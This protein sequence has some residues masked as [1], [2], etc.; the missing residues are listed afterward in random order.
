MLLPFFSFHVTVGADEFAGPE[1]VPELIGWWP[2]PLREVRSVKSCAA[3][4][5]LLLVGRVGVVKVQGA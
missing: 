3:L 4:V 2:C 1:L 5:E